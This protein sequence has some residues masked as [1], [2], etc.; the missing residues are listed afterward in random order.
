MR[1]THNLLLGALLPLLPLLA[2]GGCGS[3]RLL[4]PD[5]AQGIEG[6]ALQGPMCPVVSQDDPCPDQP[7]PATIVVQ[8]ADGGTVTTLRLGDDG[9]F[10]V[11]LEP[12]RYT[13]LPRSG[14]PLPHAGATDVDVPAG[15]WVDVTVVFDT[16]IR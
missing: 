13:L 14:D 16:G 2:L 4:G 12:G 11:G 15:V 10:R 7:Y 8:D 9:R 1:R 5:A 3:D 6:I